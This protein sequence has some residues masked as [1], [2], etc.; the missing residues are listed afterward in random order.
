MKIAFLYSGAFGLKV[1]SHLRD[2]E[3]F[4]TGCTDCT[5]CRR[6]YDLNYSRDIAVVWE[7][8]D[9]L[10]VMLEDDPLQ[11]LPPA[12]QFSGVHTVLA[13]NLHQDILLSLPEL[14]LQAG[15]KALVVP[16][17]DPLWLQG[18]ARRQV[19]Q[20]AKGT[21]LEIIFPKPFC[22]LREN[23][24]HPE[25]N[26]F[27]RHFRIGFPLFAIRKMDGVIQEARVVQSSPCGA[28]YFVAHNLA[29]VPDDEKLHEVVG[30]RWH[31]YPCTGSMKMDRE[32]KDTVLHFAGE[33][34]RE[35]VD[36]AASI[37][38]DRRRSADPAV[39][40][41]LATVMPVDTAYQ[42]YLAQQPQCRYGDSGICCRICI[43]GPC[44]ITSSAP[45]GVCGATAYTIVAR[46]LLR[47]V[48]GGTAAHSDHA[49]HILLTLK[50]VVEGRAGKD[51]GIA[52]PQKLKAVATRMGITTVGR[53]DMDILRELVAL[54]LAEYSRL[55]DGHLQWVEKT[56]TAGRFRI[57][58]ETDI[59]PTSIF[60]TVATAMSQTHLGMDADPVSLIFKTLEAALADFAGM[61]VGTDLSD[62]L[63]GVP[64][65]IYTEANLGVIDEQKVNIAV[66]GH[67]PLLSELIVMA[68]R[69]LDEEARDAGAA[70]IQLMGVCCTGNE[71]LMRQGVPLATN[72]M[73]Q[74]LPIMTGALDVM[75]VD[76]QCIMP[77]IQAVAECFKTKIVTTSQN[78]RIPGSHFVDFTTEQ[79]LEKAKEVI[80]LAIA[81]Y[82]ERVG[83]PCFIPAVK[84]QVVAGFS[85]EALYELFAA[86]NPDL[87]VRV[88]TEA[89][90]SGEL[91]GVALFV[92]CNNL[93]TTQDNNYLTIAKALAKENVLLLATG[94][95]AGA[96]AKLG[97]LAPDAVDSYAGEGLKSFIRRLE[98]ANEGK[99]QGG[100]PLVFHMGSCVD[101]TR[102]ADLAT[103]IADD[104]GVDLPKIPFVA[105]A[106]EAMT[107]KSLSIGSWNVAMGL[108]VH[109]GVIPPVLGSDLVNGI[110]LQIAHDVFG[111][112]FIWETDPVRAAEKLLAA[113]DLR[114]WKLKVHGQAAEKFSAP[115]TATW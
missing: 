45:K 63:F 92:G 107:E 77:S 70:G 98:Q 16:L 82:R 8:P 20:K 99:L 44:Q 110:L 94:C 10:P 15:V 56:V 41:M 48:L 18:G 97:L 54:C 103:A 108:P 91:R 3:K 26:K 93:K 111:G 21:D 9:N 17:E 50:A 69:D 58:Q 88:L 60:D 86:I 33:L 52:S 13:I 96:Y 90:K 59:L 112:H 95:A 102:A 31:N 84:K 57:F 114:S 72:F 51:Y 80:R 78:A 40:A 5:E 14:C 32:L 23:E 25:V 104:L 37:A 49:K 34:H 87:P 24:A 62:I 109:V 30:N 71:V 79:A 53:D 81:S 38:E 4:C 61:H 42:R 19:E 65:P 115:L 39:T 7:Q 85:L 2:V 22:A 106:P 28:A 46:N 12:S 1:L 55:A 47:S 73:S 100:L 6:Q 74:E 89:L 75:V 105:S 101:N 83:S 76:V 113:L 66:H 68:A 36:M 11:Y 67:N 64:A 29:G 43:Q 35:G 27:I